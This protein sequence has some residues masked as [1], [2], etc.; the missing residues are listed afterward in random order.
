MGPMSG[1]PSVGP[2]VNIAEKRLLRKYLVD[3]TKLSMR[4]QGNE[5]FSGCAPRLDPPL[6]TARG[7]NNPQLWHFLR[8]SCQKLAGRLH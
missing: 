2:C 3:S 5:A 7:T 8:K 6:Q 4:H 1:L